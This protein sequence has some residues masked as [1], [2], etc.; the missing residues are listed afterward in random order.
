M[1]TVEGQIRS[2]RKG[3]LPTSVIL[4]R[5][6]SQISRGREDLVIRVVSNNGCYAFKWYSSLEGKSIRELVDYGRSVNGDE[7]LLSGV[8]LDKERVLDSHFW[9]SEF[10]NSP[11]LFAI[12]KWSKGQPLRNISFWEIIR[13]RTL[14]NSI[15]EIFTKC[16]R[17][18][19]LTG[20][21]PDS[22]G[23]RRFNIFGKDFTDPLVV[24]WPFRTTNI[25]VEDNIAVLVDAKFLSPGHSFFKRTGYMINHAV[26]QLFAKVL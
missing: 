7:A 14:R 11:Q 10:D 16:E 20:R 17:S 8:G 22:V 15:A 21:Q 18:Y 13:N 2:F 4:C 23:G 9:I 1:P 12:Q 26:T 19:Q 3:V 6:S 25:F 24:I 5:D